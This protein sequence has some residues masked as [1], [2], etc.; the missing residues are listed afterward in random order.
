MTPSPCTLRIMDEYRGE[1][2]MDDRIEHIGK[3]SIIQHGKLNDRIYLIKLG[4]NDC[5]EI[6][7]SM[8]VMAAANA[9]TKIFCKVPAWAAPHFF[10]DGY[11]TEAMIPGFFQGNVTAFFLAKYLDSDRLMNLENEYLGELGEI[12]KSPFGKAK[13]EN[14]G[15]FDFERLG[16]EDVIQITDLYRKVFLSY[17]FPI[18]NPGY[19]HKSMMDNVR[20]FGAKMKGKLVAV[21]SAEMDEEGKN[22]EM[23]DFATNPDFR[24]KKLGQILL[25]KMEKEMETVGMKTVYT[26]ARLQSIPMNKVFLRHQYQYAGTLIRNTNISGNIQSMN[27]YYKHLK[28]CR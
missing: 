16:K 2:K 27:V 17:P 20:Y 24:G 19:I 3:G 10:A 9:Y 5:P 21:S 14:N 15:K 25:A 11:M 13:I 8:R 12:L 7:D 23:T 26:I 4:K 28:P 18:H 6:L 1:K 22:A